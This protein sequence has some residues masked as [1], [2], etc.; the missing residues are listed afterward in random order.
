ML[1]NVGVATLPQDYD[2][3]DADDGMIVAVATGRPSVEMEA[4]V[5]EPMAV[6]AQVAAMTPVAV[7]VAVVHPAAT[8]T[9]VAVEAV[10]HRLCADR[11]VLGRPGV[12]IAARRT[13]MER[14][15]HSGLNTYDPRNKDMK[16]TSWITMWKKY[17]SWISRNRQLVAKR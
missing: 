8:M 2:V 4:V 10:V 15:A 5:A 11:N 12:R 14:P 17:T 7:V 16:P 13:M 1:P 9:K 3:V 6:D